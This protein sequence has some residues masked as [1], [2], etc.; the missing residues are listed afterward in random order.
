MADPFYWGWGLRNKIFGAAKRSVTSLTRSPQQRA[1]AEREERLAQQLRKY[2][3]DKPDSDMLLA[4]AIVIAALE[5]LDIDEDCIS[6][7]YFKHVTDLSPA[8]ASI[9]K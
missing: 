6:L 5:K 4:E 2:G 3:L 8:N 1:I 7:P 9:F